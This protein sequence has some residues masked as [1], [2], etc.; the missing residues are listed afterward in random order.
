MEI[1]DHKITT[2]QAVNIYQI[3]NTC[4]THTIH[5]NRNTFCLKECIMRIVHLHGNVTNHQI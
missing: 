1:R 2:I 5:G 3:W 4:M